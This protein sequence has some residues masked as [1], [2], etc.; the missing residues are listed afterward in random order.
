MSHVIR[1][2]S[3]IVAVILLTTAV[4]ATDYAFSNGYWYANGQAHTRTQYYQP[5]YGGC[6]GYY[7]YSYTP[8]YAPAAPAYAAPTTTYSDADW[9]TKI[10]DLAIARDKAILGERA[11]ALEQTYYL[12]AISAL[13]LKGN[14][15]IQGYGQHVAY[16]TG[17]QSH[18]SQPYFATQASTIYGYTYHDL[19]KIYG[20]TDLMQLYQTAGRLTDNAQKFGNEANGNFSALVNSAA[21]QRARQLEIL[22]KAEA[23][24]RGMRAL[25]EKK[26]VIENRGSGFVIPGVPQVPNGPP[27]QVPVNEAGLQQLGAIMQAKCGDCHSGAVVKGGLDLTQWNSFDRSRKGKIWERLIEQNPEKMMPRAKDGGPGQRLSR[28]EIA[29]FLSN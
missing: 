13:G 5:G 17:Y 10:L 22:A 1:F 25:E 11:K 16:G 20:D 9:R 23:F 4:G 7:Y 14:F 18:Q 26:V 15:A 8:Y 6:C 12:D 3:A 2:L 19:A 27:A 28:E 29:L 21:E 24:A